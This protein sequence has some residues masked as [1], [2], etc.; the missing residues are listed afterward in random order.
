VIIYLRDAH[1]LVGL[2][3]LCFSH[4][5]EHLNLRCLWASNLRALNQ[6]GLISE[7]LIESKLS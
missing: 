1:G 5:R 2:P 3:T 7:S 6:I 4:I